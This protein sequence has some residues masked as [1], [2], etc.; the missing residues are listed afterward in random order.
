MKIGIVVCG[1]FLVGSTIGNELRAQDEF[2]AVEVLDS[3]RY[4]LTGKFTFDLD[5]TFLPLDGYVKP[6][7][8]EVAVSYQLNDFLAFEPLRVGYAFYN[9]DTGLKKSV[10]R[11]ASVVAGRNVETGES[12]LKDMR[13]HLGTAV[14][15]NLLYSKS[16]L[17]NT[18]IVYYYWQVGSGISYYDMD[19]KKQ[20]GLDLQMRVRFF[21]ND[22]TTLNIRGG[23]TIGFKSDAPDNLTFLG[24]GVGLAF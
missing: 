6:T 1:L 22:R 23:H 16:N 24:V 10:D 13:Y 11:A 9:H 14:F 5:L 2:E 3:P 15:A 18:G 17:F 19:E 21:L 7:M 20:I 4:S 8:A 12:P